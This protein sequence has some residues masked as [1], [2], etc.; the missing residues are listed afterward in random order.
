MTS[1]P[2][3]VPEEAVEITPDAA[4]TLRVR[5]IDSV[6]YMVDGAVTVIPAAAGT[7]V[8]TL[9]SDGVPV[10]GGVSSHT[11]AA[12][13]TTI[14]LPLVSAVRNRCCEDAQTLTLQISGVDAELVSSSLRVAKA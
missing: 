2:K 3:F 1:E 11:V 5:M 6:G 10:P 7:A 8:L 12:A 14:P 4:A 13:E 9:L